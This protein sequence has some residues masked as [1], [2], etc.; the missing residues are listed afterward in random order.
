MSARLADKRISSSSGFF[1]LLLFLVLLHLL[2]FLVFSVFTVT[3]NPSNT[4]D[5]HRFNA[6]DIT[7]A[8]SAI[9]QSWHS[10]WQLGMSCVQLHV[11]LSHLKLKCF[12]ELSSLLR[13]FDSLL[14]HHPRATAT[15]SRHHHRHQLPRLRQKILRATSY[16][17]ICRSCF[18]IHRANEEPAAASRRS[19]SVFD[20]DTSATPLASQLM[21]PTRRQKAL[22]SQALP[23]PKQRPVLDPCL[24][25]NVVVRIRPSVWLPH[26]RRRWSFRLQ[27]RS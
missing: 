18:R 20:I 11:H 7:T 27:P 13:A 23:A 16:I 19:S 6:R 12:L 8:C 14:H 2:L 17:H 22:P 4:Y 26:T 10:I 5:R 25:S 24:P 21:K 1:H 9:T 15:T 3:I